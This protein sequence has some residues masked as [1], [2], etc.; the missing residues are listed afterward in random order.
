MCGIFAFV[1]RDPNPVLTADIVNGAARRGPHGHGWAIA[2]G[3]G[4]S[5][6]RRLG[7]L[8]ASADDIVRDTAAI[9]GPYGNGGILL[10]HARMATVGAWDNH[11][12]LQPVIAGDITV[13]H[14]G[15]IANPD[16]LYPNAPTDS[17]AFTRAYRI[18]RNQ[19]HT[20]VQ[21]LEKL[22]ATAQQHAWVIVIADDN[23]LYAHRQHHPLW[24]LASPD[25]VY[26][27][28]HRFHPDVQAVPENKIV[29][30]GGQ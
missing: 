30:W 29:K 24:Q 7:P 8:E 27:S 21:A 16:D 18:L 28:S 11:D 2:T 6:T 12:N 22:L 1:G 3:R 17:I 13:A 4:T 5:I 20:P 25:G 9:S 19:M 10:G 23:A 26:L 15:V 14:N